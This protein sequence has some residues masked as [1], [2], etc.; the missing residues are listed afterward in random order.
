MD[1]RGQKDGKREWRG[2]TETLKG[3]KRKSRK[4]T[5]RLYHTNS[6]HGSQRREPRFVTQTEYITRKFMV[7]EHLVHEVGTG[8]Q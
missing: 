3:E 4:E 6:L 7:N 2:A 1:L 5:L 8:N